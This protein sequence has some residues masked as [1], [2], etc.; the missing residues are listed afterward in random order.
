MHFT[1]VLR[2]HRRQEIVLQLQ[3]LQD[4]HDVDTRMCCVAET[5]SIIVF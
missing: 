4:L 2:T 1:L 3:Y 5:F